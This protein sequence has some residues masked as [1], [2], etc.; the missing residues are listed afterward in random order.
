MHSILLYH[1]NFPGQYI[2]Q[3]QVITV[4]ATLLV[5]LSLQHGTDVLCFACKNYMYTICVDA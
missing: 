4:Y 5:N 2:W 1:T 3:Q